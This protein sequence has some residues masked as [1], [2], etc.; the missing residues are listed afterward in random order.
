MH[1]ID[2]TTGLAL[3]LRDGAR[4]DQ[5]RENARSVADEVNLRPEDRAAFVTLS[6]TE[7]DTQ[8]D[9]LLRKRL[10]RVKRLV[11]QL[12]ERLGSNLWKHFQAYARNQWYDDGRRDALHF[13]DHLRLQDAQTVQNAELNRLR[14]LLGSRRLRVHFVRDLGV[15]IGRCGLQIFRRVGQAGVCETRLYLAL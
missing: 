5:F 11:P 13:C 14:F 10:D 8:A 7:L 2:F 3:L 1:S 4:R 15:G 9:V 12:C 6:P